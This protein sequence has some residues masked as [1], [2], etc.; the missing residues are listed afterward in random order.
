MGAG[1][2]L[3]HHAAERLVPLDLRGDEIDAHAAVALEES[4]G[5]FVTGGFDS[6]N[7]AGCRLPVSVVG[8]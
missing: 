4:D 3:R 2:D 7:H 6:K 1:G 8:S 5:G